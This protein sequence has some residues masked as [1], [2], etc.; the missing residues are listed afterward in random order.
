MLD[1]WRN[2]VGQCPSGLEPLEYTFSCICVFL[3]I[4]LL[5]K[6]IISLTKFFERSKF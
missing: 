2:I 3:V 5:F 1:F 6:F 4:I